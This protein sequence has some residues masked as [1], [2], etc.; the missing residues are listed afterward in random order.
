MNVRLLGYAPR[1]LHALVPRAGRL[2]INV[3]LHSEPLL[4]EAI[5]VRTRVSVRGVEAADSVAF[6]DR[7]MTS[8]AVRNHPATAESDALVA[9]GGGEVSLDAEAPTGMH[10]RGG[11]A[12]QTAYLLDGIP[13]FSPYHTA[14]VFSAWNSDALT[15]LSVSGVAPSP[16]LPH[17][18][19]GAVEATTRSPGRRLSAQA[20]MSTT[21]ARL[22]LDGPLGGTGLGVL[23]SIRSTYPAAFAPEG[24]ASYVHGETGDALLACE[25]P[26][27]GGAMRLVGYA[28]RNRIDAAARAET[29]DAPRNDFGWDSRSGGAE[30]NRA[31]A[32]AAL[33]LQA[34][35]ASGDAECAWAPDSVALALTS[36]R[37]DAGILASVERRSSG[38]SALAGIR[39]DRSHSSYAAQSDTSL[40]PLLAADGRTIVVSLFARLEQ[41]LGARVALDA[42]GSLAAQGGTWHAAPRVG[43]RW[44]P[45]AAWTLSAH[46]ARTHQFTQSLRNAESVVGNVFPANLDVV[47]GTAGVP[48]ARSDQGV[49]AVEFRPCAGVR[50]GAQGFARDFQGLVLVAVSDPDPFAT[51]AFATGT[52]TSRGVALDAAMSTARVGLI[53]S[54]GWQDVR[55]GAGSAEYTPEYGATHVLD[56]GV[57]VYPSAT[58]SIRVSA[59]AALGRRATTIVGGF[60]WEAANLLDR[61]NEFAGSPRYGDEPLGGTEL[62][63]YL[64]LDLSVRKHW[65]VPLAGRDT[66]LEVFGA[67]TNLLGRTNLLTYTQ[68]PVTGVRSAVEMRPRAPLVFGLDWRL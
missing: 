14:G 28:S 37:R 55:Y 66:A 7:G 53:A 19:S 48:V 11:A 40:S 20:G 12:D 13:V 59:A 64:R 31:L 8:A 45:V 58:S 43:V 24:E 56:A 29:D 10:V 36:R 47:A 46:A 49:V 61:G 35:G 52:G 6:P 2:E 27:F 65:H 23:A 9:L 67:A 68:D 21:H 17:A 26:A 63:S 44:T 30:W 16:A 1:T 5:E 4:L 57:I 41:P 54:Y 50:F 15:G 33:R 51:R 38:R 42:A 39:V 18:L 62:P 3:A 60:E 25:S 34:W 22:T 32:G